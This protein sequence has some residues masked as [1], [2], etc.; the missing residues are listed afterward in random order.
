MKALLRDN[1][2]VSNL[3]FFFFF[4]KGMMSIHVYSFGNMSRN[5][6]KK[7]KQRLLGQN[8]SPQFHKNTVVNVTNKQT[9]NTT[10]PVSLKPDL[11][12]HMGSLVSLQETVV[13]AAQLLP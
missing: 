8:P 1:T 9:N 10:T 3:F 7:L 2:S 11:H 5:N 13:R 12:G 6:A 4:C